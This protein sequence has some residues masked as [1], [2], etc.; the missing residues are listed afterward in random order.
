[1]SKPG[2][3]LVRLLRVFICDMGESVW[4]IMLFKL[5]TQRKEM[6]RKLGELHET[7]KAVIERG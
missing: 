2:L 4:C 1:M 3:D 6:E 5:F 7:K